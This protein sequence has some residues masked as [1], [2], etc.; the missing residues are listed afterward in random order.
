MTKLLNVVTGEF[1]SLMDSTFP[2]SPD[3]ETGVTY[4]IEQS[5]IYQRYRK[6]LGISHK[7]ALKD[8]KKVMS[9]ILSIPIEYFEFVE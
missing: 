7:D 5:Y 1:V 8:A 3:T 9:D 6:Q 2:S 4:D